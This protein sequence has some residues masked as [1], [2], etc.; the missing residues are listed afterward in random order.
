MI[1]LQYYTIMPKM[2][3][4]VL[5]VKK[6]AECFRPARIISNAFKS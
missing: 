3:T 2:I 5:D 1:F 4:R 6:N